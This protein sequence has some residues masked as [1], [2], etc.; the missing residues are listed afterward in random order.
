[1]PIA[2]LGTLMQMC[3]LILFW[4][5]RGKQRKERTYGLWQSNM[6]VFHSSFFPQLENKPLCFTLLAC[7]GLETVS[8][9]LLH[10]S[11]KAWLQG[12]LGKGW[13]ST[14]QAGLRGDLSTAVAL[15]R[16]S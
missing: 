3:G 6:K 13:S 8:G 5:F 12:C 7:C 15:A 1:M 4:C 10:C 9:L 11:L 2:A 16:G 14:G